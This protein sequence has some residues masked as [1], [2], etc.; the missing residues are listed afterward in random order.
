M[1][2]KQHLIPEL[3]RHCLMTA[4]AAV[5]CC[6]V[7]YAKTDV[8]LFLLSGQSNMAGMQNSVNDLTADQKK[9]VD[10][11]KIYQASEGSY[12]NKWSTLGP[13]FGSASSNVGP[14]LL[15]GRTLSDS[16]QGKKIAIIKDSRSGTYLGK[17][18]EWLPPSSNNGTGGTYYTAMM[19][20]IDAALKSF[21]SAFDTT[22]YA[23]RWAGFVWLQGE[24]DAMDQNLANSYETNLTNLIK[25]IR[26]KASVANLPVILPM[27][28]V[29]SMWTYNSKVRAAD[30][31]CKQKLEK[32]DT[33]DTKGLP[34]NGVHYSAAGQVVI[35]TVSAKRWL[36]MR[37]TSG[38]WDVPVVYRS[39]D[40][41]AALASRSLSGA[42]FPAAMFDLRGRS[43]GVTYSA[44][45]TA[46]YGVFIVRTGDAA[47]S[48]TDR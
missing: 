21:N 48:M 12:Q 42:G 18:T 41:I 25:D 45:T 36:A 33:M 13:G 27:I 10:N 39:K 22:L 2:N 4:A 11:V 31:A 6:T 19:N 7:S 40:N 23:P 20:H 17:A 32:V 5:F 3:K 14:E 9:M 38:W 1:R 44:R 46:A 43:M 35:G 24:F 34:T 15:F 37:F 29:Q 30:V 16:L 8:P 26:T 47:H 28:D